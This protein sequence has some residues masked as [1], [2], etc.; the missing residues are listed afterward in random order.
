MIPKTFTRFLAIVLLGSGV[1]LASAHRA[2]GDSIPLPDPHPPQQPPEHPPQNPNPPM[3]DLR[4]H[5]LDPDHSQFRRAR[6]FSY[7]LEGLDLSEEEAVQWGI[8]YN[9]SHKCGTIQ[10]YIARFTPLRNIAY[11][12]RGLN[13][14]SREAALFALEFVESV[15][16]IQ[17]KEIT[18]TIT[19]M[20]DF[21]YSSDGMNLS[22]SEASEL[23]RRWVKNNCENSAKINLIR[24]RFKKE[25]SFAYSPSGLNLS[26]QEA[27]SYAA[28]KVAPMSRCGNLL[29]SSV[30]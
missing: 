17:T 19:T 8:N 10:E 12:K 25:Y 23:A 20:K 13:L 29:V 1:S 28:R 11:S 9:N 16:S 18:R 30:E 14:S 2:L 4:G 5:C 21:A 15:T 3:T 22:D 7:S 26:S 6:S 24:Q 27:V